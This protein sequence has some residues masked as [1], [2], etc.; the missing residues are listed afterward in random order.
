MTRFLIVEY[1]NFVTSFTTKVQNSMTQLKEYML[2]F[3]Y[4]PSN[5]KPTQEQ[6]SE[7][8]NHWEDYISAIA[9]QGKL[10]STYQ[11]GFAGKQVFANKSQEEG[12]YIA[13]SQILGGNMTLK[14]ES[15]E[16]ATEI[17]K[18]CPILFMGGSVEIRDIIPMNF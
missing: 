1:V 2:L 8:H 6:L 12:I 14:A 10:V 11:L 17:A 4:E 9:L 15:I 3:R 5:E 13:N 18:K 16:E 7:M